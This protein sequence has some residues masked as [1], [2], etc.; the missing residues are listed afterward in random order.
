MYEF[1]KG[2]PVLIIDTWTDITEDFL[3]EN[4][5]ELYANLQEWKVKNPHWLTPEFWLDS[6]KN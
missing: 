5:K 4:Y 3:I 6:P 1:Y 2:L